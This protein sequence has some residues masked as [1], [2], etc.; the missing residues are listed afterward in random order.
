[1]RHPIDLA[2]GL[3]VARGPRSLRFFQ[4]G[5]GDPSVLAN[6]SLP[7]ETPVP[8]ELVVSDVRERDGLRR[9]TATFRSP[10]AEHLGDR[11]G[12]GVVHRIEPAGDCDRIVVLMAAWNEHDPKAR[13]SIAEILA[14]R[15]GIGSWILVNPFY[16]TRRR[17]SGQPIATVSDFFVMGAAAVAEGRALLATIA[18]AGRRAGVSGYSM[19]GNVSALV[20]ATTPFPVAVAPL[21]ASYSPAPVYLDGVLRGGIAWE[22]LGGGSSAAGR[23]RDLMLEASVLRFEPEPHTAAAVMVAARSDGYVPVEATRTLHRHWPGS[24]LRVVPGGHATLVWFRKKLLAEAIAEA[25][26]R[27]FGTRRGHRSGRPRP[28]R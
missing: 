28:G 27:T 11:S 8:V 26:R 10:H 13:S 9:T 20:G 23:L 2:G 25:F 16:G 3:I 21:A 6:L 17:G 5:W 15:H 12:P 1:M 18:A 24:V 4:D 7:S 22:A 14:R 19:G